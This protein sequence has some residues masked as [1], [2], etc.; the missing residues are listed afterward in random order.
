MKARIL[1]TFLVV[2]GLVGPE[3]CAAFCGMAA[4]AAQPVLIAG[5]APAEG[6]EHATPCHGSADSEGAPASH[7]ADTN[8]S[9]SG[10]MGCCD[11]SAGLVNLAASAEL[12]TRPPQHATALLV[13]VN[14]PAVPS[15]VPLDTGPG[16]GPSSPYR[17]VNPPLLN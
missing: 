17:S 16:P 4:S 5:E 9:D 10:E 12:K 11:E 2:C 3:V 15:R 7:P 6:G 8:P 14:Q 13:A 1:A